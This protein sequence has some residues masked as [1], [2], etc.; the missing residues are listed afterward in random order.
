M[1][2][3]AVRTLRGTLVAL[4]STTFAAVSHSLAGGYLP[5]APSLLLALLF[6]VATGIAVSTA[7]F[8]RRRLAASVTIAQLGFHAVFSAIGTNGTVER[9]GHHGALVAVGTEHAHSGDP[10]M[11]IAH[12]IA[13]VLTYLALRHG[14]RS[15][16]VLG[17]A[18][19]G[20]LARAPR[21][22]VAPVA[23]HALPI[24]ATAELPHPLERIL[25]ALFFRG[26]PEATLAV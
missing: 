11:W 18:L 19:F 26:P 5:N 16:A 3:R 22:H 13:A 9:L 23:G 20:A 2:P 4:V 14:E 21:V 25:T 6:S 1:Q 7:V 10:A 15:L 12:A 17:H 8:S 24:P